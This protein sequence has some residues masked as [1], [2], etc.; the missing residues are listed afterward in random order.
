MNLEI[1]IQKKRK[2]VKLKNNSDHR[3]IIYLIPIPPKRKWKRV[4]S[5]QPK[6]IIIFNLDF[7]TLEL[8]RFAY[9]FEE[10]K[11]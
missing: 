10:F 11:T 9:Q 5:L 8:E 4:T 7:D 6:Q 1:E 3:M 2:F